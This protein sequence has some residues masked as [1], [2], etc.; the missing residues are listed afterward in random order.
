MWS[1]DSEEICTSRAAILQLMVQITLRVKGK[2]GRPAT[3]GAIT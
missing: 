2:Q 1:T 3:P